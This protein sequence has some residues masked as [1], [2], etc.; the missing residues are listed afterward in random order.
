MGR[1][2]ANMNNENKEKVRRILDK[3][4]GKISNLVVAWSHQIFYKEPKESNF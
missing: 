3:F 2:V 4:K 1:L